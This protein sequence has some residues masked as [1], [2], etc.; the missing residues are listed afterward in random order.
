MSPRKISAPGES[1][2]PE[3]Y[4][5]PADGAARAGG[6]GVDDALD[7]LYAAP[8]DGFVAL[9]TELGRALRSRGDPAGARAVAAAAKPTRA[10]WALNRVAR[11]KPAVMGAIVEAW[12][13]ASNAPLRREGVD[14]VDAA[15]R[16]REAVAEVVREARAALEP[17]G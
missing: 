14:L 2:N 9:R 13:V 17:D 6:D 10:A 11:H 3:A 1:A 16:Y 4:R 8:F 15:R 5:G 12:K 7:A